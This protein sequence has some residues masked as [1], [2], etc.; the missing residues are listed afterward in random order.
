MDDVVDEA[1]QQVADQ[2]L[3]RAE[4]ALSDISPRLTTD[5]AVADAV[6]RV[7]TASGA[8]YRRDAD[9]LVMYERYLEAGRQPR[10]RQM[11]ARYDR[12]LDRLVQQILSRADL[13]ADLATARL[14]LAQMDG[15]TLRA[16]A[17]NRP[18]R[19]QA[20]AALRRLLTLLRNDPQMSQ[21]GGARHQHLPR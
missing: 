2:W 17:E 1:M 6:L 8:T 13:P 9:L 11:V 19:A 4:A 3:N 18:V 14:V 12:Q 21:P 5:S 20:R 7:V 16:L 10:L 15:V